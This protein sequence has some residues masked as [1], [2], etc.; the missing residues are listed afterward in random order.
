[1]FELLT[2]FSWETVFLIRMG[3][4]FWLK[5]L[6]LQVL[7]I[8]QTIQNSLKELKEL[9]LAPHLSEY[10]PLSSP[11]DSI[12][13]GQGKIR[14]FSPSCCFSLPLLS[15]Y[16]LAFSFHSQEALEW[17]HASFFTDLTILFPVIYLPMFS[18]LFSLVLQKMWCC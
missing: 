2:D 9:P 7:Y 11:F 12:K 13:R 18:F 14:L 1:M 3:E 16:L 10:R 15:P 17:T 8:F 5:K 4:L 6:K